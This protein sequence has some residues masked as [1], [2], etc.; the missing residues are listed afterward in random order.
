MTFF[1][2]TEGDAVQDTGEQ[3]RPH[4]DRRQELACLPHHHAAIFL[5]EFANLPVALLKRALDSLVRQG[6]AQVFEGTD[7]IEGVKFS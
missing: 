3:T 7:G 6:K 4:R 2:L 1:E 5:S